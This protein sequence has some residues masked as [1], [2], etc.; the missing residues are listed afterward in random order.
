MTLAIR[1][2][3]PGGDQLLRV[4][5]D[6]ELLLDRRVDL[7]PDRKLVDED[8]QLAGED[9]E[10]GRNG[11][12][13][14]G[15]TGDD[16]RRHLLRLRPD[17]DDVVSRDP[18]RRHVDL[19]AVDQEVAVHDQ[20]AGVPAGPGGGGAGGGVFP[21]RPPELQKSPPRLA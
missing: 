1:V 21:P 8:P 13:A 7:L 20:L 14:L 2:W 11:P 4:E 5:L 9:L 16:E 3:L 18:V 19:S 12:L 10:P 15:L 17:V 6:D